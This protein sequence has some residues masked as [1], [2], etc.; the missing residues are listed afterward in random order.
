LFPRV[1]RVVG[2]IASPALQDMPDMC[3]STVG[4]CHPM[5]HHSR[6]IVA[7]VLLM[8]TFQFSYPIQVL[9]EM[10]ANNF[11]GHTFALSFRLHKSPT[12]KRRAG[13]L[14]FSGGCR[15]MYNRHNCAQY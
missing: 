10:E 12:G 7:N 9:V 15:R 8:A 13:L 6:G 2:Q 4:R 11:P 5:P 1:R 14:S 3:L